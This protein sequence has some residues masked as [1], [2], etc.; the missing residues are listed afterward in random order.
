MTN[1]IPTGNCMFCG[2]LISLAN[3]ICPWCDWTPPGDETPLPVIDLSTGNTTA[4]EMVEI[5]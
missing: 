5:P 3:W 2:R 4:L 1:I